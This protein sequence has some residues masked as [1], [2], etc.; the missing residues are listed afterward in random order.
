ML[1]FFLKVS[2][3]LSLNDSYIP[4][5]K[6]E[7]LRDIKYSMTIVLDTNK[8]NFGSPEWLWF[9]TW[10]IMTLYYKIG[11]ILLQSLTAILLQNA[12][13]VYYKMSQVFYYKMRQFYYK[14]PQ[15]LQNASNFETFYTKCVGTSTSKTVLDMHSS[16]SRSEIKICIN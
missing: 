16:Y 10:F 3:L 4:P 14:L 8:S 13:K 15:L 12:T 2:L 11:Q 6:K 7:G 9:H 1:I 5:S